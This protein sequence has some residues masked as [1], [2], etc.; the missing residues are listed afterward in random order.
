[1]ALAPAQ[2]PPHLPLEGRLVR[3][4]PLDAAA[5]AGALHAAAHGPGCDPALWRYL[6]YGPFASPAE[7]AAWVAAHATGRDPLLHA[8]VP[9]GGT[10]AG[11]AAYLRIVPEHACIEIGHVWL[12]AGLQR[13]PAAT[14]AFALLARHVFEDLGYRRLEWKCDSRNA[15]SRRAAERLGFTY[16]G[17]FRQHMIVRGASR[18]SAWFSLLDSE[19]PAA[20]AAF[21][22]WLDPA[23][24]DDA[25]RQ[26]RPLEAFRPPA[27]G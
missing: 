1:M 26:R 21:D 8:I 19:W 13:T 3:L 5:H 18:D 10:A 25:G 22:L 9:R 20:A 7:Y 17:T 27:A 12:G 23:N 15:R 11:V 4:E 6:P 2:D 24:F 16:E 14:E